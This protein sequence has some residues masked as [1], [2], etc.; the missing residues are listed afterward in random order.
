MEGKPQF[1]AHFLFTDGENCSYSPP[2]VQHDPEQIELYKH[3]RATSRLPT[4][5]QQL[6]CTSNSTINSTSQLKTKTAKRNQTELSKP[7][8]ERS[9]S[10]EDPIGIEFEN[11]PKYKFRVHFVPP[12]VKNPDGA[13]LRNRMGPDV[14]PPSMFMA[15]VLI[16]F[17]I[18]G[19]AL[20]CISKVSPEDIESPPES[21]KFTGVFLPTENGDDERLAP[22]LLATG[23]TLIVVG[24][25]GVL[26][27][28]CINLLLAKKKK[29][30]KGSAF[31]MLSR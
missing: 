25:S 22:T 6:P 18:V 29:S 10:I 13:I 27:Q 14:F 28:I 31:Q 16:L 11:K 9:N 19:P 15:S 3:L 7:Q 30:T 23:V 21:P 5:S 24:V 4:T 1:W 20:I 8:P 12:S 17:F 2:A 26:L